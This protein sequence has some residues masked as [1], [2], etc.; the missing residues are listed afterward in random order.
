MSE[1]EEYKLT[2]LKMGDIFLFDKRFGTHERFHSLEITN[3]RYLVH[4]ISMHYL[5]DVKDGFPV[6][7]TWRDSDCEVFI[8]K[9]YLSEH[10]KTKGLPCIPVSNERRIF[11]IKLN[12]INLSNIYCSHSKYWYNNVNYNP[13]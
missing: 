9:F 2:D 3:G 4:I 1:N 11:D 5:G 6:C 8:P 12:A 10:K 7:F 13:Y